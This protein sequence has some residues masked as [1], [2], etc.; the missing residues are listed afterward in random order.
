MPDL[1]II[2]IIDDDAAVL[3]AIDSLVRSLGYIT[4]TFSSA[5]EFL[6]SGRLDETDCL[7]TDVRL[8]TTAVTMYYVAPRVRAEE[9]GAAGYFAKPF[10]ARDVIQGIERVVRSSQLKTGLGKRLVRGNGLSC[11][12]P[13]VLDFR[14]VEKRYR[15]VVCIFSP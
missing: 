8:S 1:P 10:V 15:Q 7:I 12:R 5:E 14:D 3:V 4:F 2:S 9:A 13:R 6:A 11:V